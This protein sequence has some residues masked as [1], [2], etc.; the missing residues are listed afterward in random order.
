MSKLNNIVVVGK[1][2]AIIAVNFEECNDSAPNCL[3][4][5]SDKLPLDH[6]TKGATT[7]NS[8]YV[9]NEFLKQIKMLRQAGAVNGVHY[10][11]IPDVLHDRVSKGTFKNWVLKGE[12]R[13]GKSIDKQELELWADF[14]RLYKD[15]FDVV[16]FRALSLYNMK[17][18]KFNIEQV[19]YT[20]D[21]ISQCWDLI[22]EYEN[23]KMAT[24]IAQEA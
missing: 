1:K 7:L 18:P 24:L 4:Y 5:K 12:Y 23:E 8:L 3:Y 20:N 6:N 14:T 2:D 17:K 21:V 11:V 9:V 10:F 15:L 22:A 13:N 19:K 16:E